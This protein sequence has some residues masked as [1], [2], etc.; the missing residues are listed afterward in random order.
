MCLRVIKDRL[1][2]EREKKKTATKTDLRLNL[3]PRVINYLPPSLLKEVE[4]S[5]MF[6]YGI[7]RFISPH[8]EDKVSKTNSQ[9]SL[10]LMDVVSPSFFTVLRTPDAFSNKLTNGDL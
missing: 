4:A 3:Y 7:S 8:L 6:L 9:I 5:F 2:R 1:E 10:I